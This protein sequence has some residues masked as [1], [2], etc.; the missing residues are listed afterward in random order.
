MINSERCA[1]EV[2]IFTDKL[3]RTKVALLDQVLSRNLEKHMKKIKNSN[4]FKSHTKRKSLPFIMNQ[5]KKKNTFSIAQ[6]K[7]KNFYFFSIL[8]FF[9]F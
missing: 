5:K 2:P 1:M 6:K 4:I 3:Y 8:L 9:F 7:K